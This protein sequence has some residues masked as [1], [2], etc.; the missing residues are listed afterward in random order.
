MNKISSFTK[1]ITDEAQKR[2][3]KVSFPF[4]DLNNSFAVLELG[5]HEEYICQSLV[6]NCLAGLLKIANNK[7]LTNEFLRQKFF[8]VSKHILT[9]SFDE[10]KK[11]LEKNKKVVLKPCDLTGGKGITAGIENVDELKVAFDKAQGVTKNKI[12]EIIVEEHLDGYDY[13]IL[14]I[15][16]KHVFVL[17]REPAYV[18]GDGL[19]NIEELI[20][21]WNQKLPFRYREIKI[22]EELDKLLEKNNFDLDYIPKSKEK[23][24]LS[25]ISNTH[26]GGISSNATDLICKEARQMAI[27]V[28]KLFHI[29]VIGIDLISKDISK[30]GGKITEVNDCPGLLGH[31]NPT[32]G[33]PEHPE[34]VLVE[35]LFPELKK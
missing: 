20:N 15:D 9:I 22:S 21:K 11:F 18:V 12:K 4:L 17:K 3:I 2:G 14:V 27:K 25:L 1:V 31:H 32:Y 24:K 5:G 23:V 8:P 28:A 10:A 29:P 7:A 26:K 13:R 30:I 34:K 16:Y 33:K 6:G 19:S 35:M